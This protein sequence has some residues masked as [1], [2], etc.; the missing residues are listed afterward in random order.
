LEREAELNRRSMNAEIIAR[1]QDSLHR[2][3]LT[4]LIKATVLE[5]LV[6]QR[7]LAELAEQRR[8]LA[9]PAEPG[10]ILGDIGYR[11][12]YGQP[13]EPA[14]PEAEPVSGRAATNEE[15]KLP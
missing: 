5:T 13:A 12:R 8:R 14:P 4:Q 2:L 11:E 9:E 15:E 7:K 10:G 6:E 3:D 1:L